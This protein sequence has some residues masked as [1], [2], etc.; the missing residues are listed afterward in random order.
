MA[1]TATK[2]VPIP[3]HKSELRMPMCSAIQPPKSAP[4]AA[5]KVINQRMVVVMRP[6]SSVGVNACLSDKKFTKSR[7]APQLKQMSIQ[8]NRKILGSKPSNNKRL[9]QP[10]E[11]MAMP[12]MSAGPKPIF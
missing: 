3:A 6:K 9:I 11:V 4:G 12:T 2:S 7:V 1:T 8:E 10:T 5:G